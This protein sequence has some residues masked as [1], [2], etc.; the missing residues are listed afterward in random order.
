MRGYIYIKTFGLVIW[1]RV[2]TFKTL[3]EYDKKTLDTITNIIIMSYKYAKEGDR[4]DKIFDNFISA[5][6]I[7]FQVLFHILI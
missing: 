4:Y 1:T 7:I 2:K 5:L 6:V 3:W